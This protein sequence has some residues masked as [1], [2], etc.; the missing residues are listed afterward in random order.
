MILMYHSI[1]AENN[2]KLFGSISLGVGLKRFIRQMQWLKANYRIVTL[3]EFLDEMEDGFAST[4]PVTITFDDGWRDNLALAAPVLRDYN[5]RPAIFLATRHI[6]TG[7]PFW[8]VRLDNLLR[9]A[10]ERKGALEIKL[11]EG[12][13]LKLNS[14]SRSIYKAYNKIKDIIIAKGQDELSYICDQLKGVERPQQRIVLNW[15]EVR[16]LEAMG[17]LIGPHTANHH[18]LSHGS[19]DMARKEIE[20][21]WRAVCREVKDPLPVFCFPNGRPEDFNENC[22][23][24]IKELG[25]SAALTT[26]EAPADPHSDR[27]RLPRMK[28]D[29]EYGFWSFR[30]LL[31]V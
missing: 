7:E 17:W 13:P 20:E 19:A 27:F 31:T 6:S 28:V 1:I 29:G 26:Q 23:S 22:I 4:P 10:A 5:I 24:I 25:L 14:D 11:S 30:H 18:I 3:P 2:L 15:D 21:S 16:K 9:S 12:S 8:W